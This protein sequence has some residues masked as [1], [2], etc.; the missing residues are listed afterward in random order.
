M[1]SDRK[2][3]APPAGSPEARP[4]GHFVILSAETDHKVKRIVVNPGR[5]LS[6]QRHQHR[7]EH[8]LVVRGEALVTLD[9]EEI[10][11]VAG[12]SVDIPQ[13]AWHRVANHGKSDL[14]FVEVQL[15]ESFA[16]EDIERVEDD[17]GRA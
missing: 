2:E 1:S 9:G 16:E 5:R 11:L 8:W 10:R 12:Q 13:N 4:W 14:V 17:Y 7:R 6:V 3:P 15:G